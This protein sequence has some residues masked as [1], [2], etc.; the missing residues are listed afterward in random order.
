MAYLL[1]LLSVLVSVLGGY[2]SA[3]LEDTVL[4][5]LFRWTGIALA[6]VLMVAGL[7]HI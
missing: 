5:V 3:H 4:G 2:V 1:I 7:K 6:T